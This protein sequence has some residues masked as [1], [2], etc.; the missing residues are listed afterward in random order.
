MWVF[1]QEKLGL[2]ELNGV[3]LN[4]KILIVSENASF[5]LNEIR[6]LKNRVII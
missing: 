6:R 1:Y 3:V 5:S 4:P 2:D